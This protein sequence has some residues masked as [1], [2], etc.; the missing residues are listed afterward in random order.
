MG[1]TCSLRWRTRWGTCCAAASS[2]SRPPNPARKQ[3]QVA[4]GRTPIRSWGLGGQPALC[5]AL[6]YVL[7]GQRALL[8]EVRR[9]HGRHHVQHVEAAEAQ[10]GTP[11]QGRT[12]GQAEKGGGVPYLMQSSDPS[13]TDCRHTHHR[14]ASPGVQ[15]KL[16]CLPSLPA[17]L[18]GLPTHHLR[19]LKVAARLGPSTSV[20][21]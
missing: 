15:G 19:T 4:R 16:A 6:T 13:S 20:S 7:V 1:R 8:D 21:T 5:V 11:Q 17:C 10:T 9:A 14:P 2:Y 18:L 3:Q 12:D